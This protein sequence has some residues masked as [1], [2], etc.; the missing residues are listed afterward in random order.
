M[1]SS[2][3]D[4][5]LDLD[6]FELPSG[7]FRLLEPNECEGRVLEK[8]ASCTLSVTFEPLDRVLSE[9]VLSIVSNAEGSPHTV[10]LSGVGAGEAH[11]AIDPSAVDFGRLLPGREPALHEITLSNDGNL[12]LTIGTIEIPDAGRV[13]GVSRDECSGKVLEGGASCALEV[14][15]AP[16]DFGD[17]AATV[18][19]PNDAGGEALIPLIGSGYGADLRGK[20]AI[21]GRA[22][23]DESFTFKV[24]VSVVIYNDGNEPA[25]AFKIGAR[26]TVGEG[27]TLET[28]EIPLLPESGDV[29][30]Q[31]GFYVV[32][33]RELTT[34]NPIEIVGSVFIPLKYDDR[35]VR[36]FFDLDIC[37]PDE[38]LPPE[39]RIIER[40]EGNNAIDAGEVY[41]PVIVL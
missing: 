20:A 30:S 5:P 1:I 25:P 10:N 36:I 19:I 34:D 15:F 3:G 27:E 29:E 8:G 35:T 4:R 41:L 38:A 37:S 12:P 21:S 14:S 17:Q 33:T 9:S 18:R 11:L 24:P 16:V 22:A 32:T 39:C 31:D 6:R 7:P 28:V 23:Y 13:F 40:D 26:F 2:V